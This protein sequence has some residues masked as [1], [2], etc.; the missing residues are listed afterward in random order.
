MKK[1]LLTALL[2]PC[3]LAG[4]QVN[5][6]LADN[7]MAVSLKSNN[8]LEMTP[9][10]VN[11]NIKGKVAFPIKHQQQSYW[12]LTSEEQGILLTD[13]QGQTLSHFA[14]SMEALDWRDNVSLDGKKL[15]LIAT[16]NKENGQVLI[17]GL[18]WQTL[19]F[20]LLTTIKPSAAIETLCW[21][22]MP[23]GHTALFMADE[24]GKVSQ[25]IVVDGN[26]Q[27]ISDVL[28]RD[29][30]GVP[31]IKSCAVDDKRDVLYLV[32]SNIGVWRYS[33]DPEAELQRELVAATGE[34]GQLE[35][36]V[37]SVNVL[38][39]G[40]LLVSTPEQQGIWIIDPAQA[41]SASFYPL[42][43]AQ[44]VESA[45]ALS[46]EQGLNI[47]LFDDESGGYYHAKIDITLPKGTATHQV[48]SQVLPAAETTP[49]GTS[50][51]AADD[52]AIWVNRQHPGQSRIL[53]TN[54]K[55]GLMVHDLQGK[56]L[57]QLDMGRVNN[58]DVRYGFTL[59]GQTI[60]I[61]AASNRSNKSLSLFAIAPATGEVSWLSDIPTDLDDTYGLCMYQSNN[62]YYVFVNDTNGRF[63]QYKLNTNNGKIDGTLVREFNVASQ[64]EGC[65]ADDN[66]GQLYFGEEA[67][68]IWQV[69]AM[70][71]KS[72]P[73]LIAP[74]ADNF[75]ADVEGLAIYQMNKQRYLIASSQGN[76]SYAVFA[77][78]DNNR[79][80][81][82]FQIAMDL[83]KM[84]DG[85]SETDGIEIVSTP[86]GPQFPQGL[87]VAQDGHNVMPSDTQNFKLVSGSMIANV[88]QGWI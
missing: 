12:L 85:V 31:E 75:V 64:P 4:C 10:E 3:L 36:E 58:V 59:N 69:P 39:N 28:L 2:V 13:E 15:G 49:V 72:M 56:L 8:A 52:P 6:D 20:S 41:K 54:K 18:D 86:L 55:R 24:Q 7:R 68:G 30:V 19:Q 43:Q 65:V 27:G 38:D 33:A 35:G 81:G 51:D 53:A 78:E 87:M 88:I 23:Q 46:T 63:Q 42:K 83:D 76:N 44:A 32:E 70:P 17:L 21:Y 11:N 57:Q 73:V 14:G 82:S 67:V 1:S 5:N 79:Y 34:F 50:G 74:L 66:S 26:Q 45:V 84:I 61:A 9:F 37:T 80:L 25:R 47:G 40:S 22:T 48:F 77:L 29:F 62:H 71:T 16:S 60:D